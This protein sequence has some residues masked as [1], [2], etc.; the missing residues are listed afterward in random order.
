MI[1]IVPEMLQFPQQ[2]IQHQQRHFNDEFISCYVY[3]FFLGLKA[4]NLV[5]ITSPKKIHKLK[6]S[7]PSNTV[8]H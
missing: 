2:G 1:S 7:S 8:L 5:V 3:T 4:R 6:T